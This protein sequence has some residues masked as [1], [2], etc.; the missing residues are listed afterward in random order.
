M[1]AE[2]RTP[3]QP[4]PNPGVTWRSVLIGLLLIPPNCIW[5]AQ[6][7]I[8]HYSGHPTCLSIFSNAVFS[9]FLVI[10]LNL[11]LLK[12]RPEWALT[13]GELLVSYILV[14]LGSSVAAHDMLQMLVPTVP[15]AYWFATPENKWE[16]LIQPHLPR[17]LVMSDEHAMEGYYEGRTSL[18][19]GGN[20]RPWLLPLF[21]WGTFV[22]ALVFVMQCIN[23][24]MRKQWTQNEKLTYPLIQLPVEMTRRGGAS[25]LYASWVFWTGF[26]L[27]AG[28]DLYNGIAFL[29]PSLPLINVKVKNISYLFAGAPWNAIGWTP[30]SYYPFVVALS[31]FLPQDVSFS[32]WFFYVFRKLMQVFAVATGWGRLPGA[33]FLIEQA[34]GAW[35]AFAG[36]AAYSA[37]R[38]LRAVW[39]TVWGLPGGVDDS[40]EPMPYRAAFGGL[41]LGLAYLTAFWV[42][43]GGFGPVI[44]LYFI[45]YYGLFSAVTKMRA[46]IGPPTHELGSM[47]TTRMVV[48][49]FGSKNLGPGT[50]V[51]FAMLW[52]NN[53]M[54]RSHQMPVQLEGFKMA[55]RA[56]I[57]YR[58]LG[59]AMMAAI[60]VGLLS[61]YWAL[62]SDAYG[63]KGARGTGFAMETYRQLQTWLSIPEGPKALPIG[64][65]A[66]GAAFALLLG[67][68]RMRI[69][70]WPFHPAGY[71]LGMVFGLDYVWLPILIAWL[72]KV[73]VLR[74]GGLRTHANLI[75][76]MCGL[77]LGEFVVGSFWSSLSVILEKRMY[78]FWIF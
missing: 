15:H 13:Q 31:F 65:M 48:E 32:C 53:R 43:A 73:L 20:Y 75:P 35:M 39:R 78:T 51:S 55:E 18:L 49:V 54:V 25:G 37:R 77:I 70:G 23:V 61:G 2:R 17:W 10:L 68:A 9:L 1:Q 66:G 76:F 29:Y 52:F 33:P 67:A 69:A 8:V 26:A 62:L 74:Y 41:A 47:A 72:L 60:L 30:V 63:S 50:L 27:G 45:L 12:A 7:E 21:W 71:A 16:A 59:V 36:L 24:L 19:E 40:R 11:I 5:V 56:E 58:R 64:F 44:L 3:P 22:L 34:W 6:V 28:L 38:H 46:E 4:P 42:Q 57:D 14:A